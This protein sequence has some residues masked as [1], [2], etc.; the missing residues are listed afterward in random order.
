MK[1]SVLILTLFACSDP[2][3]A[4]GTNSIPL[5]MTVDSVQTNLIPVAGTIYIMT[6]KD[7]YRN[8]AKE[9]HNPGPAD[10]NLS[11]A[12]DTANEFVFRTALQTQYQL[13]AG[14]GSQLHQ[15]GDATVSFMPQKGSKKLTVLVHHGG[16]AVEIIP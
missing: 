4:G 3:F 8:N 12:W 6:G 5:K 2:C 11:F 10:A 7:L 1:A 15:N 16:R 14:G 13:P 9:T